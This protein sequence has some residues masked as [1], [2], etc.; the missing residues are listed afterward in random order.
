MAEATN[1]SCEFMIQLHRVED[2]LQWTSV[3]TSVHMQP[4]KEAVSGSQQSLQKNPR[5]PIVQERTD[6]VH[7]WTLGKWKEAKM[8]S[9]SIRKVYWHKVFWKL[10]WRSVCTTVQ[11]NIW[12]R[13][14]KCNYLNIY[15]RKQM[16][17]GFFG[18]LSDKTRLLKL[19]TL[20]YINPI[21][22]INHVM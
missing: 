11:T 1:N 4:W 21:R 9:G 22:Q 2:I 3:F 20:V 12:I 16:I 10:L 13:L 18:C 14:L 15:G 8:I 17:F 19:S 6:I 5:H 7:S